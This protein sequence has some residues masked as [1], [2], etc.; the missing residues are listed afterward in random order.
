MRTRHEQAATHGGRFR[1]R[2]ESQA[3]AQ[4]LRRRRAQNQRRGSVEQQ[5]A[6]ATTTASNSPRNYG[7]RKQRVALAHDPI[8]NEADPLLRGRVE[9]AQGFGAGCECIRII[10]VEHNNYTHQRS[11][12]HSL[13]TSWGYS[14]VFKE[15]SKWDDFYIKGSE[16]SLAAAGGKCR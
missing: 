6:C 1:S 9:L 7:P 15:L 12:I 16:P 13:L 11:Q 5:G 4:H 10:T 3:A 14:Q 2:Y 8:G